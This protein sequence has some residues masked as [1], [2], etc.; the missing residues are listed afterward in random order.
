MFNELSKIIRIT[1]SS[2]LPNYRI[3]Y[4]FQHEMFN[5]SLLD[6]LLEFYLSVRKVVRK[7]ISTTGGWTPYPSI[8]VKVVK[9]QVKIKSSK[10]E[11]YANA[12][13]SSQMFML[14]T[15]YFHVFGW[16]P[17][18]T[19]SFCEIKFGNKNTYLC[20]IFSK[21]FIVLHVYALNKA[22]KYSC[23]QCIILAKGSQN[24][25]RF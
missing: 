11:F 3:C 20:A 7:D 24:L 16:K 8:R 9:K 19:M 4:H 10:P 25:G 22:Q 12:P 17:G 5:L 21:Y 14:Q 15:L 1:I 18:E 6:F 13:L 23:H 2:F